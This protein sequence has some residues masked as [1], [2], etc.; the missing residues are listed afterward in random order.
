MDALIHALRAQGFA[1][2]G[3]FA[4]SLKAPGVFDWLAAHLAAEPPV[5][6]LNAT[7]FSA[8][9]DDGT[10]ARRL[11]PRC[12]RSFRSRCPPRAAATG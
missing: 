12:A 8:K 4:S 6:I 11:T 10:A 3:A 7:A 5:A 9:T 1:A 2:Y